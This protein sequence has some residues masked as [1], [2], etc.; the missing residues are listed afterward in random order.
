MDYT[1]FMNPENS[2]ESDCHRLTAKILDKIDF[3][4]VISILLYEILAYAIKG[5]I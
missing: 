3:K 4:K 1:I 5:K 2:K